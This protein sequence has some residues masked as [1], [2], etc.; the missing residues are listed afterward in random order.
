MTPDFVAL[1]D[2]ITVGQ[3]LELLRTEAQDIATVYY[4]YVVDHEQRLQGVLTLRDLVIADP[5]QPV[6]ERM[7]RHVVKVH[8]GTNQR[9]IAH[10]VAHYDLLSVPVV[11]DHDKLLGMVT[12]DDAIDAVIPTAWKKRIPRAFGH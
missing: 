3:A 4:V 6:R 1:P 7:E 5:L 2:H 12:V 11:D 10:T 8:V 9:D